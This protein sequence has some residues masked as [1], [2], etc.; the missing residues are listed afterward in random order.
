MDEEGNPRRRK[1]GFPTPLIAS[2]SLSQA[3]KV[4]L[5]VK[6]EESPNTLVETWLNNHIRVLGS[7]FSPSDSNTAVLVFHFRPTSYQLAQRVTLTPNGHFLAFQ[8]WFKAVYTYRWVLSRC[9]QCW[10]WSRCPFTWV[11]M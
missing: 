11:F 2:K 4:F 9:L 8:G 1:E 7:I 10:T 5:F 3:P 6:N